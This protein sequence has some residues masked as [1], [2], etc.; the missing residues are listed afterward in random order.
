MKSIYKTNTLQAYTLAEVCGILKISTRT[1]KAKLY[2]GEIK[3]FKVG[4]RWRV[5]ENELHRL[6][7]YARSRGSEDDKI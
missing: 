2:A 5:S 1:C 6:L 4:N 7:G 3:G